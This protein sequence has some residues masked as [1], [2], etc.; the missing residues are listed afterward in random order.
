M[1]YSYDPTLPTAKD[2][3]RFLISDKDVS[4]N[5][6]NAHLAD[7]EINWLLT[8]N[9]GNVYDAAA[10]G[11]EQIAAEYSSK[12]DKMVGPLR[13]MH[14]NMADRFYAL[15]KALRA[16]KFERRGFVP[17]LTA[18]VRAAPIFQLGMHDNNDETSLIGTTIDPALA[19]DI[20]GPLP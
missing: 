5:G 18:P 16:R 17:L 10:S 9:S 15:A 12:E 11:A 2:Q 13:L 6:V 3:V 14:G 4:N 20:D 19:G 1:A 8:E 7:E